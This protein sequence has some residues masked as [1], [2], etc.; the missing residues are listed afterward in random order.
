V[1]RATRRY[2]ARYG[3]TVLHGPFAGLRYPRAAVGK[4]DFLACKLLGQY[5]PELG[6]LFAGAE[7][8]DVFVNVGSGDGYYA[9]GFARL[10]PRAT[11]IGFETSRREQRL[12][13]RVAEANGVAVELRGTAGP[14]DLEA[15][16]PGRL[17][18]MADIEGFEYDLLDPAH[19]GRLRLATMI[20]ELHPHIRPGVTDVLRE[21]FAPTHD[22][23]VVEGAEKDP[24]RV[25]EV[26]GWPP[27]PANLVVSEGKP[28]PGSWMS[29]VPR[30]GA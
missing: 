14:A 17:L 2:L 24:R 27:G 13:R 12:A 26:A 4:A 21:R 25:P 3:L 7:A 5:E 15:L 18:L 29:L 23:E 19:A 9:V 16:P 28:W 6:P 10:N 30:A 22:I 8:F 20:V 11:V 1:G